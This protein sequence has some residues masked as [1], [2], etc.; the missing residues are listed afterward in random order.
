MIIRVLGLDPSMRNWG[1][2]DGLLDLDTGVLTN[3]YLSLVQTEDIEGK[4][5]RK[6][7]KDLHTAT[8][9]SK[10]AL[11]ASKAA[12]IVFVEVPVG[13]Q[14]ANGMK[15]YGMCVGILG[16]MQAQGTRLIEVTPTEVKQVFTGNKNAT[17]AEM[18]DRAMT[19]YPDANWPMHGTKVSASKAEH[20]ADATAA[21]HAGVQTTLFQNLIKLMKEI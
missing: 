2:A 4:Q 13:S 16:A 1:M 6:N 11:E 17:K 8:Q 7:S 19:Y 9:L 18:I 10:A 12:K 5:V 3:L 21:I 15:S 20:L 14:S